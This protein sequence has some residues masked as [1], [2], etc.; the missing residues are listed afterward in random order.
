M[1]GIQLDSFEGINQ[2]PLLM[3]SSKFYKSISI[4]KM[5]IKPDKDIL[6]KFL[7]KNLNIKN[8][9]ILLLSSSEALDLNII[10]KSLYNAWIKNWITSSNSKKIALKRK[11]FSDKKYSSENLLK[12]LPV[13]WPANLLIYNYKIVIGCHS[14]TLFEAANAG[15]KVISLLDFLGIENNYFSTSYHKKYI[16]KNLH[17]GKKIFFPKT[18][19]QFKQLIRNI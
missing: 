14:A 6:K 13:D 11:L 9:K 16:T 15:C 17:K 8:N 12:E 7:K 2:Q 3:Y 4:K 10:D 1:Y 19:N 5:N 18:F